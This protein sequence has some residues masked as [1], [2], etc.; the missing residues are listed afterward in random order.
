L[1]QAQGL[2]LG[3]LAER[4]G[5]SRAM[6]S[7]IER[8]MKHPTL[9]IVIQIAAALGT[10]VGALIGEAPA[11]ATDAPTIL[12][13]AARPTLLDPDSGTARQALSPDYA[14]RGV[15]TL[16]FTVPPGARTTALP[17]AR[18]GAVAQ[19][20]VFWGRLVC[21]SPGQTYTLD[22]GDSAF[23]PSGLPHTLSNP[24]AAPCEFLLISD[25]R[26]CDT[27]EQA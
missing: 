15:E 4:S 5:V 16:W 13:R 2:S 3:D 10:T 17:P 21:H 7:E 12:P 8:D 22:E 25:T 9:R 14:A 20:I 23:F 18:P 27:G 1:R 26:G 24:D 6:I 11:P 19:I